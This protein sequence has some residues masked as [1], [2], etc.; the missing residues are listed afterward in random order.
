MHRLRFTMHEAPVGK[1]RPRLGKG[2]VIYTPTKTRK[3]ERRLG[4]LGRQMRHEYAKSTGQ[5]WPMHAGLYIVEVI[6]YT[7][8]NAAPDG[9]NIFKCID[10]LNKILWADDRYVSGTFAK[11]R[12]SARPRIEYDVMAVSAASIRLPPAE[13]HAQ[14]RLAKIRAGIISAGRGLEDGEPLEAVLGEIAALVDL[15]RESR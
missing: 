12:I 1:E 4:E 7:D 9:D 3:F 11:P 5:I 6:P 8:S 10:G 14:L 15:A 2:G 13:E